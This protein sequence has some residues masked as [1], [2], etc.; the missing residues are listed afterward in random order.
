[1]RH[2]NQNVANVSRNGFI[3]SNIEARFSRLSS[4]ISR[5]SFRIFE[6]N[7]QAENNCEWSCRN[8]THEAIQYDKGEIS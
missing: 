8:S 1:M 6:A 7:G 3:H 4:L 5:I 2:E